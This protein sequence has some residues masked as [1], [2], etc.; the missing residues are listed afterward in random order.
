M[1]TLLK[2]GWKPRADVTLTFVVGELQQ[3]VGTVALIEQ[4]HCRADVFVNCEPSDI[5]AITMHAESIV[6]RIEVTGVTRQ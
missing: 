1:E 4:G 5:K 2:A 3:G 6:F